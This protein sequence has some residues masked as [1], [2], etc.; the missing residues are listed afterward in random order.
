[1]DQQTVLFSNKSLMAMIIPL[2][3]EQLQIMLVGMADTL[4]VSYAGEAAVSGVHW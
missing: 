1:M 4:V 3:L 2:F